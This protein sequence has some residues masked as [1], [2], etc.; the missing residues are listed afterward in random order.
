MGMRLRNR[1]REARTA[2]GLTQEA[3]ARA[4]EISGQTLI[5][6][7][8]DAGH[9]PRASVQ[10]RLCEALGDPALFWFERTE[11]AARSEGVR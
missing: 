10:R 5:D 7:E 9:E 3:L 2:A 4:A 11:S 8:R 6:I 1:V